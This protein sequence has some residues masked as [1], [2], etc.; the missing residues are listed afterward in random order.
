LVQPWGSR[1][2]EGAVKEQLRLCSAPR[3]VRQIQERTVRSFG[4][5]TFVV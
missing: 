5:A 1:Q 4:P 3:F 2:S